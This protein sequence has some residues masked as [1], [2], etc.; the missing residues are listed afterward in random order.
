MRHGVANE[1]GCACYEYRCRHAKKRPYALTQ[2]RGQKK[3]RF[4]P[5]AERLNTERC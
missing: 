1:T 4:S 2:M 5:H 3:P